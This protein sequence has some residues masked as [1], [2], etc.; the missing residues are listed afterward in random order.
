MV[1]GAFAAAPLAASPDDQAKVDLYAMQEDSD[2]YVAAPGVLA[3]DGLAEGDDVVVKLAVAP[4][5]GVVD[6]GTDGSFTYI[7]PADFCGLDFF[8]YTIFNGAPD[9][10]VFIQ[11]AAVNDAPVAADDAYSVLQGS[12]LKIEAP[13][14]VLANDMDI[15]SKVLDL[16][17]ME[18][19]AHG[20]LNLHNEGSFD[21][22]PNAGF[23]GMDSFTY[24]IADEHGETAIAAV[25]IDVVPTPRGPSFTGGGDVQIAAIDGDEIVIAGWAGEIDPGTDYN[26]SDMMFLVL[27]NTNAS[28]FIVAPAIDVNT[29]D[30]TFTVGTNAG[31]V[32]EIT[33]VLT[34]LNGDAAD[35]LAMTFVIQIEGEPVVGEEILAADSPAAMTDGSP[36]TGGCVMGGG[37][38]MPWLGGLVLLALAAGVCVRRRVNA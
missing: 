5:Y 16:G 13:R 7:P 38:G 36:L 33:I 25:S 1:I 20:V 11:V 2:L 35:G 4:R 31:G 3:N 8:Y 29:G 32:A 15:D 9:T 19:P 6:M 30:L 21:Y 10:I 37:K 12:A 24:Y 18:A 17:V 34:T 22:V 28:L 23:Y 27:E 26:L 14:G